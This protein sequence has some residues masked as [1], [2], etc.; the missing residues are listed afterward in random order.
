MTLVS[1][2]LALGLV[3]ATHIASGRGP[4][5]VARRLA[6][7]PQMLTTYLLHRDLEPSPMLARFIERVAVLDSGDGDNVVDGS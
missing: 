3:G 6:G 7:K 2:G 1:A 5:V 4:G